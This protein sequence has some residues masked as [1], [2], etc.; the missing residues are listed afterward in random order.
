MSTRSV[1]PLAADFELTLDAP[2]TAYWLALLRIITG[3]WFFHAG[4]TK[5][6]ESGLN[7]G[8]A[9]VFLKG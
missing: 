2:L 9:P 6:L 5:L 4:V 1:N 8:Y 3:W 7:Y